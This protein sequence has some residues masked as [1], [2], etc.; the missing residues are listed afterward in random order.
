MSKIIVNPDDVRQFAR[1]L[2]SK[3]H[4]V[5]GQQAGLNGQFRALHEVW[6]D[7]KYH[8]FERLFQDTAIQLR[9][10]LKLAE[11]YADYLQR[12]ANKAEVY[13]KSGYRS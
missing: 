4:D 11:Q 6:R 7:S 5:Q 1:F 3:A 2:D 12:K 10:F 13:T 8:Q 9:E